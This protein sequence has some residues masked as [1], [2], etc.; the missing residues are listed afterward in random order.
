L[1]DNQERPNVKEIRDQVIPLTEAEIREY[2]ALPYDESEFR[3][4]AGL[5]PGVQLL[6]EASNPFLQIWRLPSITVHGIQ[7]NTKGKAGSVI[8][9]SAW[10]RLGVSVAPGMD[11]K[12]VVEGLK[13]EIQERL[14]WNLQLE[15]TAETM[16]GGWKADINGANRD[17]YQAAMKALEAGYRKKPVYLGCGGTIPFVQPLAGAFGKEVPVLMLGVEDPYTNAHGENESM[18]IPDFK[19]ACKSQV[20]LLH[21]LARVLKA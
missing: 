1:I 16:A 4:Q 21:E 9:D 2:A 5:L 10:A 3:E 6:K 11:P 20:H 17:A 13:R 18:L 8:N 19:M 15:V 7:A 12:K 14:P